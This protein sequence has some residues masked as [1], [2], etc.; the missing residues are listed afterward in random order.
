MS[1]RK[2]TNGNVLTV[3]IIL[4]V[5]LM[6]IV[7]ASTTIVRAASIVNSQAQSA[8]NINPYTDL[9]ATT[10]SA[11]KVLELTNPVA[12]VPEE[13]EEYDFLNDT[14][15]EEMLATASVEEEVVGDDADE[16]LVYHVQ[17]GDSFW[18]IAEEFY[19]DGTMYTYIMQTNETTS[20]HPGDVLN[21]YDPVNHHVEDSTAM[22][23]ADIALNNTRFAYNL[24]EPAPVTGSSDGTR[25]DAS[26]YK[27]PT[28][29]DTTNMTYLGNWRITGYD[30]HCAH[31]CGKT[32]GITASGNQAVLGYSCGS[33]SLPLGTKIYIEGYGVYRVDDCGGSSTNLIDIAADSH[34]ICYTLTGNANVY[35]I[36]E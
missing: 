33:N 22:E 12:V 32:N 26:T 5:C 2:N 16:P 1:K 27:D 23:G 14:P 28:P 24:E 4:A 20:L 9:L 29:L 3:S 17:Y 10:A 7:V 19:N 31:C 25:P 18:G 30:P 36:N 21:L 11:T 13:V 8:M 34:D 35:I 15:S 6:A